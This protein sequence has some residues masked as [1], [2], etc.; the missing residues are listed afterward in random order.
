M[1]APSFQLEEHLLDRC[2]YIAGIDEV[3]RGALAGPVAGGIVVVDIYRAANVPIGLADSKLLSAKRRTALYQPVKDWACGSAVGWADAS[4]VDRDGISRALAVAG[5]DA[6]S[7][8]SIKPEVIILDGSYDWL[9]PHTLGRVSRQQHGTKQPSLFTEF[10]SKAKESAISRTGAATDSVIDQG[11]SEIFEDH[12]TKHVSF[13]AVVT[14]VK[15]D[16]TAASVAAASIIAK[17]ERDQL[18]SDLECGYGWD[19]NKGYGSLSHRR[20]IQEFGLSPFH[21]ASFCKKILKGT[22][23]EQ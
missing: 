2:R 8:L 16:Q 20:A 12:E 18:M 15:A 7:Q 5:Y 21:R 19:R 11:N 9:T 10:E 4:I 17:V 22:N 6:L 1:I 3:C 23:D 14:Q 13:P